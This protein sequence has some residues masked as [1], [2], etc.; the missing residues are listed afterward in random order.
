MFIDVY[1]DVLDKTDFQ[2]VK[3]IVE[4]AEFPWYAR[5][6]RKY[7]GTR[8]NLS[9]TKDE[10]IYQNNP[11]FSFT[12]LC[13]GWDNIKTDYYDITHELAEK[14]KIKANL[15]DYVT[16]RLRWRMHIRSETNVLSSPH[17]D[18]K[19]FEHKDNLK[20][21]IFYLHDSD[22]PT[23]IY[24]EEKKIVDKVESK[25]NRLLVMPG[26]VFHGGSKPKTH[27]FRIVLNIN[28]VDSKL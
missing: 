25:A 21:G 1:D 8:K 4:S 11:L 7:Y 10:D 19:N 20:I 18:M 13:S 5:Y 15:D 3:H 2:E 23:Y 24:D 16:K 14:C 12:H 22:S 28:W 26:D 27:N 9:Y 17:L 6:P